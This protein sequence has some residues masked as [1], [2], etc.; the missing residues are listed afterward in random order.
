MTRRRLDIPFDRDGSARF[1]PWL[2][3]LMVYLAALALSG[4]LALEHALARWD[5]GLSGMLTVELPPPPAAAADDGGLAAAVKTLKATPGVIAARPLARAD[6]AKLLEP[7]LGTAVPPEELAMPRLI[8]VRIDTVRGVD[9]AVLRGAL[10]KA[11]PQAVLDDHRLWLDRLAS[12]VR[13]A[14]AT[15]LAVVV[16]IGG[17]AVMTVIFTTRTGLSVHRDVIELLHLMGARDG[18]IATQFQHHALRLGLVGGMIGLALAA[19]TLVS[20]GHAADAAAVLGDRALPLPTLRLSSGDWA[21]LPLLPVAAAFLA[22]ITARLTVL[23][24]LA[25][26][27]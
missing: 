3:A 24:A 17:A 20:L 4:A 1:L 14:E 22:M 18:Y 15:A 25:R 2:I 8:D 27:P 9:L 5:R 26:M 19:A 10:A 13:S 23:G 6:V 7:W 21:A 12:L 11:A 16:L